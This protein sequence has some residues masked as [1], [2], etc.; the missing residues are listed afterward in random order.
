MQVEFD[1]F[2][3]IIKDPEGFVFDHILS[4]RNKI[5]NETLF[6]EN[7]F[8]NIKVSKIEKTLTIFN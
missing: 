7:D 4:K 3:N 6:K 1:R 2:E 5:N 8:N